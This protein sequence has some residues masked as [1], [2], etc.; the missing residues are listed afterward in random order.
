MCVRAWHLSGIRI[1]SR[2]QNVH[3]L[4]PHW[5]PGK[6]FEKIKKFFLITILVAQW[7]DYEDQIQSAWV[8]SPLKDNFHKNYII[9]L[10]TKLCLHIIMYS[11]N[12]VDTIHVYATEDGL[13]Y[14]G[15]WHWWMHRYR[16]HVP[17]YSTSAIKMY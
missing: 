4:A 15:C 14:I 3:T 9:F 11:V 6:S 7:L 5:L 13:D 17:R 12:L 1:G 2:N 8:R 10:N 16:P